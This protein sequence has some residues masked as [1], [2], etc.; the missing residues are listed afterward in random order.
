MANLTIN[1][2]A[3]P[4][5]A[6]SGW[7]PF[8]GEPAEAILRVASACRADLIVMETHG[9]RGL[10]RA[11]MG[12]VAETVLRLSPTPVLTVS[13]AAR[14]GAPVSSASLQQRNPVE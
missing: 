7:D 2:T 5:S 4:T 9:R 6:A 13:A 10:A 3:A 14:H 8:H 11:L 12:S 1:K